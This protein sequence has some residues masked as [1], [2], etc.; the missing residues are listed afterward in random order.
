MNALDILIGEEETVK[1]GAITAPLPVTPPSPPPP[2]YY[3]F[4]AYS[5]ESAPL[6]V[7]NGWLR[8]I[9]AAEHQLSEEQDNTEMRWLILDHLKALGIPVP[10]YTREEMEA[11]FSAL[12]GYD[13]RQ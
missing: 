11:T 12:E 5:V 3:L 2:K 9:G 1:I 10:V 8:G 13:G 4:V 7:F 6:I